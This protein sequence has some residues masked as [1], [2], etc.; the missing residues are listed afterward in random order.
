MKTV[1]ISSREG[2]LIDRTPFYDNN[3]NRVIRHNVD[4][5]LICTAK[6]ITYEPFM[7]LYDDFDSSTTDI[8]LCHRWEMTTMYKGKMSYEAII[9]PADD[10][11]YTYKQLGKYF[12][13]KRRE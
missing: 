5:G 2:E 3:V 4:T 13:D 8:R 9:V 11:K 7:Y 10:K 1:Y 6:R 12:A